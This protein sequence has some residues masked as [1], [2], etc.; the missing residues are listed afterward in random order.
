MYYFFLVVVVDF[1]GGAK[2]AQTLLRGFMIPMHAMLLIY[3][4]IQRQT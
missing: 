2:M 4:D 1:W 3:C